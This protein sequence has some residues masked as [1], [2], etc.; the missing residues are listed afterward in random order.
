M[1]RNYFKIAWRNI[2]RNKTRSLIHVLGL[3]MG[4]AICFLIFNVVTHSYSFDKFHP[5]GDRIFRIN[6]LTDWGDGGS[7]PNSGTP[8]PLGEV[9][10]DEISGLEEKGR[11]YTMYETLVA[12]PATDKV[13]GRSDEVTFA[14][15]GFF[16]IFP[17]EWLAGSPETALAQPESVVISE[18]SLHKYFPGS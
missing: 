6:T 8:G 12:L 9:I 2:L 3:S 1:W 10:S 16:K 17:R 15:P 4:I 5:D 7:F 14:D 18:A 13:F 11:I